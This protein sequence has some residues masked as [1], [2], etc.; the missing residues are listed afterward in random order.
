MKSAM[1]A[2]LWSAGALVFVLLVVL[3]WVLT[4][5]DPTDFR[6]PIARE[7]ET[8]TG[9]RFALEGP[10]S[11]DPRYESPG[12]LFADIT[13]QDAHLREIA[14]VPGA[15]R[16]HLKT[17][18]WSVELGD[19]LGAVRGTSFAGRGHFKMA[20]AD[21]RGM[22][23]AR[24]INWDAFTPSA[25]RAASASGSFELD[26]EAL[27]LTGLQ[28][29][30]NATQIRGEL[31][32]EQ[33][34]GSPVFDFDLTIPSL[35]LGDFVQREN[36]QPFDTLV[37]LNLPAVLAAQSQASGTL[38]IGSLHSAGV[39][40]SDVVMPLHAHSGRVSA[41]PITAG[42]YG[43]TARVDTLLQVNGA[44]LSFQTRQEVRQC[45]IGNL[46][47]DL[48]LTEMIEA[49][50]NFSATLAFSGVDAVSR[51]A[52]ARGVIRV[53][54]QEGRVKGVNLGTW[55]ERLGR[56]TLGDGS[57]WAGESTFTSLGDIDAT[58][59]VEQGLVIN[60]DLAFQAGGLDVRGHG[61]LA[62]ESGAIDYRISLTLDKPEIAAML[63][64][65]FNS[66][67]MVLP[68]RISGRW[69]MPSL[70]I[71]IPQMLQFQLQAAVGGSSELAEVPVDE[72]AN[73]LERDLQGELSQ[74]LQDFA[75]E[76]ATQ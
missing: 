50:G 23:G 24:E 42:F 33:W 38:R 14:G 60:E 2:L 41:S 54:A 20:D 19:L 62:L 27:S 70:M 61:G 73:S 37:V 43:G 74:A 63:P 35:D 10:I 66:G 40:L 36:Q 51:M 32:V 6:G 25:F 8:R 4:L 47:G 9:Y 75:S 76:P 21:L 55:I 53:A 7:I 68:L 16:L 18:E 67:V 3:I 30:L 31:E 69:D 29:S 34:S 45:Q 39:V 13:V 65:P 56:N 28:L 57:E 1:R 52:S 5:F 48:G 12:R 15:Q 71:D 59:R 72:Y 26:S 22:L 64:P 46:L 17:L 49:Q 58:L 44:D 11:F